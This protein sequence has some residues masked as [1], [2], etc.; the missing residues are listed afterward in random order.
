[1]KSKLTLLL[2]FIFYC[3]GLWAQG[4][5]ITGTVTSIETNQP[6]AGATVEEAGGK[7]S[8]ITDQQGKFSI[9][10]ASTSDTLS[11]S[12]VGY[13]PLKVAIGN[14][15]NL[16]IQLNTER[17]SLDDVVVIGYGSAK[18]SDLTGSVGSVSAQKI[19]SRGSTSVMEALQGTVPGVDITQNSTKPGAGFNILIRGQN[20]LNGGGPLYVVDGIVTADI[21]FLNPSDIQRIDIL[22]DASSTAIYGSRGSNGVVI[23]Q[24]KKA[25]NVKA[26]RLNVSYDGYYGVRTTARLPEFMNGREWIDY[27]A[28]AYLEFNRTTRQWRND[29]SKADLGRIIM[30]HTNGSGAPVVAPRLYNQEYTDWYDLVYQ[31]GQQQNHYLNVSGSANKLTYNIGFGYQ[32]EKGNFANEVFNRYNLKASMNHKAS[33]YFQTGATITLSQLLNDMGSSTAYDKIDRMAPFFTPYHPDGSVVVQPG[34]NP[35]IQSDRG[36]TGT[37]SPLAEINS[38]NRETRR[39][40]ILATAF[41][42]VSPLKSLSIRSTFSP[43]FL[44][45]RYGQFLDRIEDTYV[46]GIPRPERS[47]TSE[48]S[49]A[50]EYTWD[51]L[52]NYKTNIGSDHTISALGVF[53]VYSTRAEN[54][55][56]STRA[57]PYSSE[58]YNMF[59]GAFDPQNSSSSYAETKL[60]SYLGR[61]NYDYKGK[62]LATA[63]LRYDGSSKLADKW[64]S[65]PSFAVAWRMSQEPF[66]QTT[67]W[68][69]ELK[70]RFSYGNSGNNNGVGPFATMA[71]PNSASNILYNFGA[72]VWSGFSPGNPVNQ[73]LTWEKTRELNLG[74]DFGFLNNRINGSIELYDKLS[75][76]LLMSRK[77][78]IESGVASMQDNIGSVNNR[79]IELSLN[80]INVQT[81]NFSWN[82]TFT[83]ASNKNKIVTL[84]GKKEDVIGEARFIGKP[85]SVI[86][87]YRVL[88]LWT[89]AEYD[90]GSSVY[91][92]YTAIPGE[93]KIADINDDKRINTEDRTILGSPFPDWVGSLSSTWRYKN[94]DLS[95]FINTRQGMFVLDQF[96]AVYRDMAGRSTLK[97]K[98]FNYYVPA[99]VPMP[100]WDNFVFDASGKPIDI[101]FKTTTEEKTNATIPNYQNNAG[102]YYGNNAYYKDASFVKVKNITLGYTLNRNI[103]QKAKINRL[104]VYA[105]VLN[106]FVFTKYDGYDPE[107]ATVAINSGNGPSTITYQIGVNLDF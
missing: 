78:A 19:A 104:R 29:F 8:V 32:N 53:S 105:N 16:T 57:L 30:S 7:A 58:W 14:Q 37:N 52:V 88:G 47:A 75:D 71:S 72:D 68:L 12:Y 106:P 22:K 6:I 73:N 100:D 84:Y 62:Y 67:D 3:S 41:V 34:S 54:L 13:T 45:N 23:I 59:S 39:H 35:N 21:T 27:R 40:D 2:G 93:A 80:T 17:K 24:T 51:N 95:V 11:I 15:S 77:L 25:D 63:S 89:K 74:I 101:T 79:G 43:R 87:D 46:G 69:T 5:V 61:V 65:F 55:R 91:L 83:F 70:L 31:D 38:E 85:I 60:V 92:N 66:L 42:E 86:Y 36:F 98:D 44:R 9:T 90:N 102:A 4:R 82:T 33:D 99:G 96:S 49:E 103:L 28:Y 56:V 48:N 64:T 97:A 20:S 10:V 26:S 107:Y 1:M 76:G 94:W 18:K 81:N 50:F